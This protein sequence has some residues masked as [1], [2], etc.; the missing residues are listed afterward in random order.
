[1]R[2]SPAAS[3][4]TLSLRLEQ[5]C[6]ALLALIVAGVPVFFYTHTQDQFELPKL[7]LL[8]VLSSA[9]IG[10]ALAWRALCPQARWRRSPLDWPLL[11]FSLWLA[12]KTVNSVSPALS[13][14]GEYENFAG[15]LTQLNYSLLFWLTVQFVSTWPR[16]KA[17][18]LA[19]LW[20][21]LGASLYALLQAAQADFISWSSESFI[22]D[23]FFGPLGNPNFLAGLA[24]M[25]I[26]L[27]LAL[28]WGEQERPVQGRDWS[29]W[30]RVAL[31]VS[32]VVT[33]LLAG[34]LEHLALPGGLPHQD[35]AA[36]GILLLWLTG[37]AVSFGLRRASHPRW[38]QALGHG[39]DL[40][41]LFKALANTG[42]RGGFLG[43]MA[44]LAVLGLGWLRWRSQGM[45]LASL[46]KRLGLS[47][48]AT[49]VLLSVA[50][51]G[52]GPSFRERV[53]ITLAN[54]AFA[55]ESSRLQIWGP[56]LR[57]WQAN[58]LTGT[59]VDT[60]KSVFPSYSTSRFTRYDGENVSSRMAHCE[61]LQVLATMGLIGLSLWLAF[62]LSLFLAWWQRLGSEPEEPL[63]LLGLGALLAA[64]LA[65]N[66]VSFGVSS[67]SVPFFM[68]A[69]LLF[70]GDPAPEPAPAQ[71][72]PWS[73]ALA[74][75]LGLAV[76]SAGIWEA[77]RTAIADEDYAMG[78]QIDRQLQGVE[79]SSYDDAQSMASYA[80]GQLQSQ[81]LSANASTELNF[82]L[83]VL[84]KAAQESQVGPAQMEEARKVMIQGGSLLLYTLAAVKLEQ[85]V[86]L[87][88]DE[89][90]Y[91]VY[92]GLAYEELFKHSQ[93]E[94]RG[95]WFQMAQQTYELSVSLNPQNAYYHGNLGR[96]FG[97]GAEA[98]NASFLPDAQKNYLDA[99]RI[100]PVTRLFYENLLLLYARYAKVKEAGALL[101]SLEAR[102]KELAPSILIAA[103]STF[104]QWRQNPAGNPAWDAA[105]R[106]AS[107]GPILDWARRSV[108]LAPKD[109]LDPRDQPAFGDYAYTLAVFEE[110]A[111]QH[112]AAK[113]ALAQGLRWK[114][115]DADMLKFKKLKGL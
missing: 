104:Y 12:V 49:V 83:P 58:P 110:D 86:A 84:T 115:G 19:L 102:D 42:T 4:K 99:I 74:L 43:L 61:P 77:T 28:A 32:A 23:R 81:P 50:F 93:P 76:A 5:A 62:C 106:K 37:I 52:L 27:K 91:Q 103:A 11:G 94:R 79:Q 107:L 6:L 16:A 69:A 54:P 13:W 26:P 66:L 71:R 70:A 7:I 15:S 47:A 105:A 113:A 48:L 85:A 40:L 75:G 60:F 96:L 80:I 89:V 44:G 64:Y 73:P 14:R 78:T 31:V 8:R 90:K 108:A 63:L 17:L 111:G 68:A 22:S 109:F 9:V 112:G 45:S 97:M 98:G 10:C 39:L 59:G 38:A 1:V 41:V 21:A 100:A 3:P 36:K 35:A 87:C 2:P 24:C 95:L 101:D 53:G 20:G 57:I 92:L 65:Q 29:W 72:R 30:S 82:W 51:M 55:L 88:P 67:I 56:A 25:A 46:L 33:Y 114:P 18:S 34:K